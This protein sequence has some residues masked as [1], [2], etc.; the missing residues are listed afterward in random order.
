MQPAAAGLMRLPSHL[1]DRLSLT[2]EL[3]RSNE[4]GVQGRRNRMEV[5]RGGKWVH[6]RS[7]PK[8]EEGIEGTRSSTHCR[9]HFHPRVACIHSAHLPSQLRLCP[10]SLE[11]PRGTSHCRL[12]TRGLRHS[13]ALLREGNMH[14]S[15]TQEYK[16]GCH[17][18]RE[19]PERLQG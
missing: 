3:N 15:K 19:P 10:S 9:H 5:G 18:Y 6:V 13:T 17:L 16:A 2:L 1:V 4:S 11:P 12:S 8:G 7:Q 14:I